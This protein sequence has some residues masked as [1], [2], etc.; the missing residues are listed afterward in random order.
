MSSTDDAL[1]KYFVWNEK[2]AIPYKILGNLNNPNSIKHFVIFLG[3][4]F[5]SFMEYECIFT[6]VIENLKEE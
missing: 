6:K 5:D 2:T 3:D 4:F 1:I